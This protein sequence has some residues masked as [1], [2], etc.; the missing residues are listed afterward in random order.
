V[1]LEQGPY[2]REAEFVHDEIGT[3]FLG[4]LVNDTKTQPNTFRTD[5][6]QQARRKPTLTYGRMVGGGTVHFTAN[7]WRFHET[8]FVERSRWG[9][10]AGTGFADWPI[11]YEELVLRQALITG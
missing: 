3:T 11:Q 1:V 7:Y 8:D 9:A 10:I 5:E 2:K 4:A 6:A